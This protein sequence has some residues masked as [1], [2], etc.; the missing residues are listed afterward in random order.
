MDTSGIEGRS[1]TTRVAIEKP[2]AIHNWRLLSDFRRNPIINIRASRAIRIRTRT[3]ASSGT[4]MGPQPCMILKG[5]TSKSADTKAKIAGKVVDSDIARLGFGRLSS[6]CRSD[7]R[8][9]T[10]ES[11]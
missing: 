10:S 11:L 9:H 4:G 5:R 1:K 7:T 2:A 6:V 3:I 8:V